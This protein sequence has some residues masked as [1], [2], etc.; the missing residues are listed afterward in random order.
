MQQNG[1][2]TFIRMLL[3]VFCILSVTLHRRRYLNPS[4][5][6]DQFVFIDTTNQFHQKPHRR[7]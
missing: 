7:N 2:I 6:D 5:M 1:E 3:D 4:V